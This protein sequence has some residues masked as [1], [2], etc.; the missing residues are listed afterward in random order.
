MTAK[1]DARCN[2]NDSS[3]LTSNKS[4]RMRSH[5]SDTWVERETIRDFR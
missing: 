4:E 1:D 5:Y 2:G 3:A